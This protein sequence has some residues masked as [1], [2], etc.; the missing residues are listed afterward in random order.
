MPIKLENVGITVRDLDAAVSFFSDLGLSVMGRD[1]VSGKWADTAVELDGN[2]AKIAML[3]TPDGLGRIELF[4][5]V[6]PEACTRR[7]T[8]GAG[9]FAVDAK[10]EA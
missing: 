7:R 6:Y 4:E 3:H 1:E 10:I 9:S 2:H 5:Y 8:P